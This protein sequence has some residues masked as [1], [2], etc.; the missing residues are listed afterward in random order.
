MLRRFWP[1]ILFYA[2]VLASCALQAQTVNPY[3][4]RLSTL[5]GLPSQTIY[6][7]FVAPNGLLYIGTE[8]GLVVYD[9][10]RFQLIENPQGKT[11]AISEIK[12][13]GKGGIWCK[14]F[15]SQVFKLSHQKLMI[16]PHVQVL[17]QAGEQ[18]LDYDIYDEYLWITTK[19][20]FLKSHI[21][22]VL[23][24]TLMRLPEDR[25]FFGDL[26]LVPQKNQVLLSIVKAVFAFDFEG[27]LLDSIQT[28]EA[29]LFIQSI[30]NKV[31]YNARGNKKNI[32]ILGEKP[33]NKPDFNIDNTSWNY[34]V[35][36]KN[37]P[38]LTT[39]SGLFLFD[40]NKRKLTEGVFLGKRIS[41][42]AEDLEGNIWIGTLDDG[43]IFVPNLDIK[44]L[45]FRDEEGANKAFSSIIK[46]QDKIA[47]GTTDGNLFF[48]NP[49][50]NLQKTV[51]T[52]VNSPI[53]FLKFDQKNNFLY[54]SYGFINQSQ[55]NSKYLYFGKG[56]G[57]DDCGNVLLVG[58]NGVLLVDSEGE[59]STLKNPSNFKKVNFD[60]D[61]TK[62]YYEILPSRGRSV[63]EGNGCGEF[64]FGTDDGFFK[65]KG[66]H[67][68]EIRHNDT[69]L[70]ARSI[71]KIN[72]DSVLV[73]S[74][75]RGLYLMVNDA[76]TPVLTDPKGFGVRKIIA[77]KAGGYWLLT[78][79]GI[80]FFNL[81]TKSLHKL[82]PNIPLTG[83]DVKDL[84]LDDAG[85][86]ILATNYGL[87]IIPEHLIEKQTRPKVFISKIQ[88]GSTF[89]PIDSLIVLP[90]KS[91]QIV[92][93]LNSHHYSS[94][95]N[96]FFE[97]RLLGHSDESWTTV[98]ALNNKIP[99][100]SLPPGDY[101]FQY[102]AIIND[103]YA[104]TRIQKFT[105]QPPFWL[106][107]WFL[108]IVVLCLGSLIYLGIKFVAFRTRKQEAVK[109]QLAVS[110]IT[111]LRAQMS[112]HFIF[113]ILNSIQGLIYS[114]QK[115]EA[116]D[117]LGRFSEL[118]R[119]T[120]EY[121]SK[122]Y[123]QLRKEI[124]HLKMYI[125]LEQE[126]FDDDFEFS[127]HIDPELAVDRIEIPSMILQPFVE[128]AIKHGLL[129][130]VGK[131][132]LTINFQV[133]DK[134]AMMVEID[135]N[136]VG[137]IAA[138]AIV[139]RRKKHISFATNSIEERIH[140][141]NQIAQKPIQ[142]QTIDKKDAFGNAKGTKILIVIPYESDYH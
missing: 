89:Y 40:A 58:S 124:D 72:S 102:R 75:T 34:W 64:Y 122:N 97:Y 12:M 141:I 120:L 35:S 73:G 79:K 115:N 49:L 100:L 112:P 95:G 6:N 26:T 28:P 39:N 55:Q 135:D 24:D 113:N 139:R 131:K 41:H 29:A 88:S 109:E 103:Y 27:K 108:I 1:F 10:L 99:Y 54:H 123:I 65:L 127:L 15:S 47:A 98:S 107:S 111:A 43:L 2:L 56:L 50:H 36:I 63:L 70:I 5:E 45:E 46:Y 16:S 134:H 52:N 84:T 9:G 53:E 44:F 138:E 19:N 22:T 80:E 137:R 87:I 93:T 130:Q 117:L 4:K 59:S 132:R 90:F 7:L 86:L 68:K 81:Q 101:E 77:G 119:N 61:V 62:D 17:L 83:I 126:R 8:L 92:F 76:L 31:F 13:D 20:H 60:N 118:M 128:N 78:T 38:Y 3:Y 82:S 14:N 110:Q 51:F 48:L 11:T 37:K 25:N 18:I 67:L 57:I 85:D 91:N 94:F 106:R 104:P 105:I 125:A 116:S 66:S 21:D 30:Q 133:Y 142:Y 33:F 136:G 129:H 140:L 74:S 32:G 114:N 71:F 69:P 121:S 42:V 96:Y 23:F